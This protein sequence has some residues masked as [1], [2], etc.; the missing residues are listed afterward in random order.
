[1]YEIIKRIFEMRG[2]N[3]I[4]EIG[5]KNWHAFYWCYCK[6]RYS[7]R[8][9]ALKKYSQMLDLPIEFLLSVAKYEEVT[10]ERVK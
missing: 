1:M 8:L 7:R 4:E 6:N 10:N 9:S 3:V 5:K 2:K